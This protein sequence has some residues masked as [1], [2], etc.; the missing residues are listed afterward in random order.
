MFRKSLA[1][2]GFTL[3]ELL[4]VV[5][6]IALLISILLPSLRDAR[7]QAKMAKCLANYRG[8]MT[9]TMQYFL[10]FN[11]NFPFMNDPV[12]GGICTWS[13][14][15]K[16]TRAYWYGGVFWW[17]VQDKPMNPYL[18]GGKVERDILLTPG[19]ESSRQRTEV[20]A[21][22]C[23]GDR[24]SHQ[25]LD[26]QS[27]NAAQPVKGLSCYDDTGTSYQYNLHSLS[28][29]SSGPAASGES[30]VTLV[31]PWPGSLWDLDPAQPAMGW[32]V[33]GQAMVKRVVAKQAST[34]VMFLEDP[35]DWGL[36]FRTNE[37]GSHGKINKHGVGFLDGHAESKICD[38]R[39]LCGV[40]WES[41]V[42][43]WIWPTSGPNQGIQPRPWSY[44]TD[45][46]NCDPPPP[47]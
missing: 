22:H 37:I 2:R 23:P 41:I 7:E 47:L 46:F 25:S 12:R 34:Y 35:M 14:G 42:N 6:I 32:A 4:V 28:P 5:A 43:E 1:R 29:G 33:A 21:A 9:S 17:E 39:K 10:D 30:G 27:P 40:G 18:L 45:Y 36:A 11:D 3:I 26:W 38:T 44:S 13:Y 15:G 19:D 24:L 16:T 31:A 20:E 8:L